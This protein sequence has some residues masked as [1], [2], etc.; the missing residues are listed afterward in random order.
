[1]IQPSILLLISASVSA[2]AVAQILLK[3][4]MSEPGI[5]SAISIGDGVSTI[6]QI[7]SNPWIIGGFALY[8]SGAIAWL[9]VLSRIDAGLAYPFVGF[10]F[11]V[12]MFLGFFF[13]GEDIVPTRIAG[14]ILI[15]SGLLLLGRG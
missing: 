3:R 10:G 15:G 12:T 9:F 8:I 13:L 2:S 1:M 11:I 6:L 7:A 14:A 4:G 5:V